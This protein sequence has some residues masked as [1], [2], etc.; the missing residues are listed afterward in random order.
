MGKKMPVDMKSFMSYEISL[1]NEIKS[2]YQHIPIINTP[3][4]QE[5]CIN[6]TRDPIEKCG[7][8]KM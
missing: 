4:I 6:Q 7:E 2:L 1:K 3:L 5:N 8:M